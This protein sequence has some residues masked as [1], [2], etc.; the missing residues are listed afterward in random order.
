[1]NTRYELLR[2]EPEARRW[3]AA[4]RVGAG[5]ALV[6]VLTAAA[7]TAPHGQPGDTVAVE[8]R[9]AAGFDDAVYDGPEAAAYVLP[10]QRDEFSNF[11]QLYPH[12]YMGAPGVMG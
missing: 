3:V 11:D 8:V 12:A 6:A 2:N 7:Y 4:F 5:A 9:P 10:V 1:M